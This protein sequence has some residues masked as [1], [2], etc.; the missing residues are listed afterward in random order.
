MA[1]APSMSAP[2]VASKPLRPPRTATWR[3]WVR[4]F[5][6]TLS[7]LAAFSI[8][9]AAWQLASTY[10][11]NPHLIPPPSAVASAAVPMFRSG[12]MLGHISISVVRVLIG[13]ALGSAL[14]IVVG[15][16]MGRL[17]VVYELL[18]P[19]VEILRYLSPT[20][21][22]PIAVI[23]FGLGETSKYFLIFWGCFFFV[24]SNTIAGVLRTP[25]ARERAARCL[26]ANRLQIFM[27]VVVPAAVPYIVTGMRIARATSLMA[28]IP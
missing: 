8:A 26:G 23:W 17:R 19:V 20:A 4:R 16:I 14:A 12:E 6:P 18:D 3:R 7:M 5:R 21:M 25:L 9:L 10:L 11:V 24:L 2:S 1:H 28:I 22:I 27:L 13:F 15:V